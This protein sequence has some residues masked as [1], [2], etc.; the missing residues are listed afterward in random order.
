MLLA[1]KQSYVA[2][3]RKSKK[4]KRERENEATN[5]YKSKQEDHNFIW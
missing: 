5:E 2:I 4:K 1:F 3:L